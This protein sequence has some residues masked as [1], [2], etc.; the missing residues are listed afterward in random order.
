[1]NNN[2]QQSASAQNKTSCLGAYTQS[3]IGGLV[4][5]LS[6]IWASSHDS[7]KFSALFFMILAFLACIVFR[8]SVKYTSAVLGAVTLYTITCGICSLY[9]DSGKYALGEFLK[10]LIG[11][12]VFLLFFLIE[13]K[14]SENGSRQSCGRFAASSFEAAASIA[15]IISIDLVSTRIISGIF[16]SVAGLISSGYAADSGLEIGSRITSVYQNPNVFAGVMGLSIFLSLALASS[17]ETRSERNIHLC[18]LFSCTLGFILSFSIGA[19]LM[20]IPALIVYFLTEKKDKASDALVMFIETVIT[21]FAAAYIIFASVFDGSAPLSPIPL[22]TLIIGAVLLCLIDM[23]VKNFA[24]SKNI[25]SV[26]VTL[27]LGCTVVFCVLYAVCALNITGALT[28]SPSE[29]VTR[30][31]HISVGSYT[32]SCESDLPVSVLI[33]TQNKAD[34]VRHTSTV[35]YNGSAAGAEFSVPEDSRL[36]SFTFSAENKTLLKSAEISDGARTHS[37][38]LGYVLIPGFMANRL[39]GLFANENAIQRFEFF[40]DGLKMFAQSP[41]FGL[42]LGAFQNRVQSIQDFFYET[43][44]SHNHYI[45]MLLQGGIIGFAVF[46]ALLIV[47]SICIIRE[48][49]KGSNAHNYSAALGGA[50]LFMALHA[51][52]E[53]NLS[54]IFYIPFAFCLFAI[55][56]LCTGENLKINLP[57]LEKQLVSALVPAFFA[58]FIFIVSRNAYAKYIAYSS[59]DT[60]D[61][62][63]RLFERAASMD[64]YESADYMLTYITF[65]CQYPQY[66]D[67][68]MVAVAAKYADKLSSSN[69]RTV[70]RYLAEYYWQVGQP[71]RAFSLLRRYVE[72][73]KSSQSA[74]QS[75]FDILSAKIFQA[76]DYSVFRQNVLDLYNYML[77]L[78][79]SRMETLALS[80]NNL[81][82]IEA[83]Q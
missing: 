8:K 10:I 39:Q 68:N 2:R 76:G 62:Q 5:F 72:M 11:F 7:S 74:W 33:E 55:I 20:F 13:R 58:V 41:I 36:I 49:R 46:G 17:S 60:F 82:F 75:A 47:P 27:I 12:S 30:A 29:N 48:L 79:Q 22:V 42:G 28:L 51:L 53:V 4:L 78:N 59:A 54:M 52:I 1:M 44:Y 14:M 57:F 16:T 31:Q 43:K 73:N 34:L 65:V 35:L 77:E 24:R 69:S 9:A 21:A 38:K 80:K 15:S 3:V 70:P 83:L 61:G 67:E 40:K 81:A 37:I 71:E 6:T 66:T 56:E 63:L 23:L 19:V 32:L 45:E 18:R 26:N 25:K 50:L 64:L